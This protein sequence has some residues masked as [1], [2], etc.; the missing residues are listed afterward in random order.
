MSFK[1]APVY[2]GH[3]YWPYLQVV[4]IGLYCQSFMTLSSGILPIAYLACAGI[5]TATV[6]RVLQYLFCMLYAA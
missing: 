5:W 2:T 1:N 3:R 4:H 6:Q